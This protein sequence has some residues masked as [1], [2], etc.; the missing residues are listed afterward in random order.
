M[1]DHLGARELAALANV[2]AD[3]VERLT[4][5]G[6][7]APGPGDEPF[8]HGDVHRVRLVM[9]CQR[10]GL[11]LERIGAAIRDGRLSLS[12][13]DAQFS[14]VPGSSGESFAF[15]CER[16]GITPDLGGRLIEAAGLAAPMPEA[17]ATQD[18]VAIVA[19]IA[20]ALRTGLQEEAGRH[21]ARVYGESLRRI[22]EMIVPLYHEFVEMPL[23]A[24]GLGEAQMREIALATGPEI[25]PT[26]ERMILALFHRHQEHQVTQHM[27]EHIEAELEAAGFI[28]P[29][30]TAP[31]A[32]CFLDLAG[33][34]RLT[35][36]LGDAAAAG[37]AAELAATAQQ[38]SARH[39]GKPVKWLGDGVMLYFEHPAGAVRMALQMVHEG[40]SLNLPAIH[41]GVSAGPVVFQGGDYYGR[42]VNLAARVAA[43]AVP[44]E[45]LATDEVVDHAGGNDIRFESIGAVELKG[46]VRPVTLHRAIPQ[47]G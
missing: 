39:G 20:L 27:V 32:L 35:E 47:N 8:T 25:Q 7:L 16:H 2:P 26:V 40:P 45:V 11:P 6:I 36:E 4:E 3:D 14:F 34:T 18:D 9:A 22:V 33:Y 29:R 10:A 46:F 38:I 30:T 37:L 19:C 23:L 41:A 15:L 24:A 1:A 44:G 28:E 12:Y 21:V 42:T 17:P 13:V 31:P 5:L 43:H